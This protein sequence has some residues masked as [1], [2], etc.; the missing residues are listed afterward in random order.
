MIN[1][2]VSPKLIT[3]CESCK[4]GLEYELEDIKGRTM[5]IY[6]GFYHATDYKV[7]KFITCPKC[8]SEVKL[9]LN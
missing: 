6:N 2:I 8:G 9:K 3:V 5:T 1:V 4:S 7:I